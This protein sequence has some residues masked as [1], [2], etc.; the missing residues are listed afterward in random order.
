MTR[1]RL[2]GL[3]SIGTVTVAAIVAI[4]ATAPSHSGGFRQDQDGLS[5]ARLEVIDP[6]RDSVA[7]PL[8]PDGRAIDPIEPYAEMTVD[9][10]EYADAD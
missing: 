9:S 2:V 1:S 3:V 4:A 5:E 8:L 10:R 7:P 6:D